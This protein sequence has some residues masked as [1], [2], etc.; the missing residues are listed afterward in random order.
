MAPTI[1]RP[2]PGS[3]YT[4]SMTTAPPMRTPVMTPTTVTIGISAL[5]KAWTKTTS[6]VP[7]PFAL[8]VRM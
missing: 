2:T 6:P 8:A 3:E 1:R 7:S 5:R 4:V